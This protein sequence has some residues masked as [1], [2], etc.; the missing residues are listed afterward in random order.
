MV[1]FAGCS[2]SQLCQVMQREGL[3]QLMRHS[4]TWEVVAS[5]VAEP[6]P[7]SSRMSPP[8]AALDVAEERWA[9]D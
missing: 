7:R 3:L 9:M 8:A 6:P 5:R 1:S 2:F 4:D